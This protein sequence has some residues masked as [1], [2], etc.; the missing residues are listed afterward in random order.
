MLKIAEQHEQQGGESVAK[1]RVSDGKK[2]NKTKNNRSESIFGSFGF[3]L[4]VFTVDLDLISIQL[5]HAVN[6]KRE[7]TVFA[8]LRDG[9]KAATGQE[10][11]TG[12]DTGGRSLQSY[13]INTQ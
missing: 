4:F 5:R 1:R 11:G 8:H 10:S 7:A 3:E 6:A 2:K 9:Q 13:E 12:N